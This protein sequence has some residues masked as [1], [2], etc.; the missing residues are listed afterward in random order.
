[1]THNKNISEIRFSDATLPLLNRTFGLHR[2]LNDDEFSVFREWMEEAEK[3]EEPGSELIRIL[4]RQQAALRRGVGGWNEVELESK[5][6]APLFNLAD[7]DD[8][9]IGYFMERSLSADYQNIKLFGTVDGII[10]R[11]QQ[12]PE[13]PLFCM[14]EYKRSQDNK[15]R[16][17][18]Q[19]L[20]AMLAAQSLNTKK[21][22]VY[23]LYVIGETWHFIVLEGKRYLISE[24]YG[25]DGNR[26][27]DIFNMLRALKVL[28][29]KAIESDHL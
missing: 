14:Q 10:A 9:T 8:G 23:G 24:S 13:T 20:A 19:T 15:G 17:D 22:P 28:V 21:Q 25:A 6:I 29:L 2:E 26:L 16:A 1:M 3:Q 5:F 11:G 7:F 4:K 27:F 12:D 18:G